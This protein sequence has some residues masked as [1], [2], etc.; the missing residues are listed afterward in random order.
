M[1]AAQ[2]AS[3]PPALAGLEQTVQARTAEWNK[4]SQ[5]LEPS[6]IKLLP[7][8]PK[9]TTSIAE[10]TRAS[11]ARI[12]SIRAYLEAAIRQAALQTDS[13]K[14]VL[15]SA[16]GLGV[17]LASEKSDLAPE[18]AA[19]GGQIVN[20]IQGGKQQA[21]FAAPEDT[22][23]QILAVEQQRTDAVDSAMS[24]TGTAAAALGEQIA[25]LQAR[26]DALNGVQTAFE[27]EANRWNAYYSA[28]LA[29]AQTEC[30]ITRGPAPAAGK[31]K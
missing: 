15:V 14:Q 18:R 22:L 7:C 4:L 16:Q 28:R 25:Q 23:K 19:L 9:V 10:V 13:A 30:T 2:E 12:T 29:R 21:A 17:N 3:A 6:I 24:H 1:A 26:Q 11:D 20:L 5:S 8:D 31:K 27:A